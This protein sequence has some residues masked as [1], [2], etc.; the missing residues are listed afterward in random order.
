MISYIGINAEQKATKEV[1]QANLKEIGINLILQANE[2][3]IFYK[4]HRN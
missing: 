4:R 1:L 2:S 3:T